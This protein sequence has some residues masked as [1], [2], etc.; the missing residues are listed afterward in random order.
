MPP[1]LRAKNEKEERRGRGGLRKSSR[2]CLEI[3]REAAVTRPIAMADLRAG[4]HPRT[5]GPG[6]GLIEGT[7][8]REVT[9]SSQ[10]LG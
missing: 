9:S 5:F 10:F 4:S 2:D 3:P 6:E 7:G 1:V 8:D